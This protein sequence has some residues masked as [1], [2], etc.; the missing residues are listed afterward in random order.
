MGDIHLQWNWDAILAA[1]AARTPP[2]IL[3]AEDDDSM[4]YLVVEALQKDGYDVQEASDG[5]LL[6][7][8]ARE[9]ENGAPSIDL[10]ISDVRMP[11]CSG[12]EVLA[13]LRAARCQIPIV[14]MTA[15]G[16]DWTRSEARR[17]GAVMI[18]KPFPLVELR[19]VVARMLRTRP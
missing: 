13:H 11:I 10:L 3:V 16:D 14:L 8:L 19:A 9:F 12:L 7:A 1:P 4:R 2:R 18:D 5:R 15:F 6:A 17:L